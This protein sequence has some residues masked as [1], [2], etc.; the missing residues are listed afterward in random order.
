LPANPRP[1]RQ[2]DL[3]ST[4]FPIP[5]SRGSPRFRTA[6][7]EV[8]LDR[9]GHVRLYRARNVS[10]TG[11]LLD[12]HARLA[13]GERVQI[14]LADDL[15]VHGTVSWCD[16]E[17]CGVEFD[18]AIHCAAVLTTDGQWQRA[19]RRGGAPRLAAMRLAMCHAG[20]GIRA[21]RVIDVSDRGV[22]LAHDGSLRSGMFLKLV[23]EGGIERTGAVRWSSH[24]RAGI[25]LTEPLSGDELE[26]LGSYDR[27]ASRRAQSL[28]LHG[29]AQGG[30]LSA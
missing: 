18:Q 13:V 14:E 23:V 24:G 6:G 20:N 3:A 27:L 15:A 12:N 10:D 17:R 8:L 5:D 30:D 11:I 26:Y 25:R 21:V 7:L 1:S 4:G 2:Y 9:N 19:D 16:A 22:G 29:D 28:V